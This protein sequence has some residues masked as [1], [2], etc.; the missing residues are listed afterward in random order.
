M[1]T[2]YL[3]V[4]D[5]KNARDTDKVEDEKKLWL[6]GC[7]QLRY[8]LLKKAPIGSQFELPYTVSKFI[9]LCTLC[10]IRLIQTALLY[11]LFRPCRTS[12]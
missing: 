3:V 4:Q 2:V 11:I 9:Q 10:A 5:L 12:I 8:F 1:C 6:F 7:T